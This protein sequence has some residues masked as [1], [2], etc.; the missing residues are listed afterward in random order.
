MCVC[1]INRFSNCFL[2]NH[3]SNNDCQGYNRCEN[4]GQ[5]FQNNE[6]CPTKSTCICPDCYYGAKCQFSTKGFMF[7]L[8]SILGYHI[9]PKISIN[10]QPLIIKISILISTIILISGLISGLLSIVTFRRKKPRQ[11]GTGYYLLLSSI[12]SIFTIIILTIKFWQLIFS[13]MS[14]INNRSILYFNCISIDVILKIF[15]SSSEWLNACVAIERIISIMKGVHFNRKKTSAYN[16]IGVQPDQSFQQH[17]QHQIQKHQHLLFAPCM[18]ILLN[19]PRLIISFTSG[20]MR[21][22]RK[23]WLY[24]IGYFV[25]FIP[26][27]LMF[28]VFILPSKN[29]KNE[30]NTMLQEAMIRFRRSS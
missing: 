28:F 19:L 6:T 15:L 4:G 2:F 14:L 26:S 3:T 12:T 18:L 25:S 9:K 20:C 29:Y 10:R 5:C 21:S 1:D 24:L 13:Q 30:F 27:M 17:L 11:V 22:A 16:R 8:D 23:P 7:S